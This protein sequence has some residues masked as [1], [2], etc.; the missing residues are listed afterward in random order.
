MANKTLVLTFFW[1]LFHCAA[2]AQNKFT[3]ELKSQLAAT[4]EDTNRVVLMAELGLQFRYA[5]PDSA[6]FYGKKH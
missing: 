6:L 5:N 4:H 1:L 3:K 2:L